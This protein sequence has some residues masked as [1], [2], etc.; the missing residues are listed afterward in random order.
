MA[1]RGLDSISWIDVATAGIEQRST[2]FH[3]TNSDLWNCRRH[4]CKS[5]GDKTWREIQRYLIGIFACRVW[6]RPICCAWRLWF[7]DRCDSQPAGGLVLWLARGSVDGIDNR[8]SLS[9]RV[10][11]RGG[12]RFAWLCNWL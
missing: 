12:A 4:S 10:R 7:A 11:R 9:R 6:S 8:E 3:R 1:E 2:W 5:L